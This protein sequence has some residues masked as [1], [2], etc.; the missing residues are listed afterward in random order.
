[1]LTKRFLLS[2]LAICSGTLASPKPTA[3]CSSVV[4][5]A[6]N[7][8]RGWDTTV[9]S[10]AAVAAAAMTVSG[11]SNEAPFCR[12]VASIAYGG[13]ETLNFEL[14]LP[15]N[16][17]YGGRFMAVGTSSLPSVGESSLTRIGGGGMAGVIDT[18][19]MMIQLNKGFAV[20]G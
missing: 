5:D 14:W 16:N 8:L 2:I 4:K 18:S 19:N 10:A 17:A 12:V 11:V 15:E 20:S 1:M 6:R 9:H 7:L 13:N 3:S